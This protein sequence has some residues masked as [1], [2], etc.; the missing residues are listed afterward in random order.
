MK[1]Q[2]NTHAISL[3]TEQKTKTKKK[4]KKKKEREKKRKRK[5]PLQIFTSNESFSVN[6]YLLFAHSLYAL[7]SKLNEMLALAR[8]YF[9]V[10]LIEY[11]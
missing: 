1:Y 4:R 3:L 8:I 6:A 5:R 9:R 11:R 2:P 10:I 7:S